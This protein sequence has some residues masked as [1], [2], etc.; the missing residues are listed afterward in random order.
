MS[1][2][3][4]CDACATKLP[5]CEYRDTPHGDGS[6]CHVCRSW[7]DSECEECF[8]TCADCDRQAT[9]FIEPESMEDPQC[10]ACFLAHWTRCETCDHLVKIS[11]TGERLTR[12]A[13][14]SGPAEYDQVCIYCAPEAGEP[15][16]D[17]INDARR[18]DGNNW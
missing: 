9:H 4:E 12:H 18:D 2:R 7:P 11:D 17:S 13:S 16:W 1:K 5:C 14:M 10:D 15:D 3:I 8:P 6:F